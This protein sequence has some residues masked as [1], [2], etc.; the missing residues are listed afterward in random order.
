MLD[1]NEYESESRHE[2]KEEQS[3]YRDHAI[4]QNALVVPDPYRSW[5]TGVS[6][7]GWDS[8]SRGCVGGISKELRSSSKGVKSSI[9]E[10]VWRGCRWSD[11][12]VWV[13]QRG[14]E[15]E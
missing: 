9:G 5:S 8:D 6:P 1:N 10:C 14:D 7:I 15:M 13:A 3:N 2:R 12:V 4:T 11:T